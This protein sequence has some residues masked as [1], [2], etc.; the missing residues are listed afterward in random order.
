[1]LLLKD[2]WRHRESPLLTAGHPLTIFS[3]E[4]T[5][6]V[7]VS[8]SFRAFIRKITGKKPLWDSLLGI[9][10]I[11]SITAQLLKGKW[12]HSQESTFPGSGA[13]EMKE[14]AVNKLMEMG[15]TEIDAKKA[16]AGVTVLP[17]YTVET[18]VK[19]IVGK[20]TGSY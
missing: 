10:I 12:N 14:K 5:D 9:G 2:K 7:E 13:G 20:P 15:W 17:N 16:A 19:L 1:M 4:G 6:D 11:D 8:D 3:I 18:I